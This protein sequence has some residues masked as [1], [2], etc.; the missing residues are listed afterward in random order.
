MPT[1]PL[2]ARSG[3]SYTALLAAKR[4]CEQYAEATYKDL[5][6]NNKYDSGEPVTH[7]TDWRLPTEKEIEIIISLQ[8]TEDQDA[9]AIDYLLNGY[10]YMSASGPVYNSKGDNDNTNTSAIRCVR[11]AY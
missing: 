5:N 9:P 10:Y 2:F 3:I 11:D 6:N 1:A 7:Y 8:G 4:H